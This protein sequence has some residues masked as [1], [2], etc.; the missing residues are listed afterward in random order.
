MLGA[1]DCINSLESSSSLSM[2]GGSYPGILSSPDCQRFSFQSFSSVVPKQNHGSPF[3]MTNRIV[4]PLCSTWSIS[5]S[6]RSPS[7]PSPYQ[8]TYGITPSLV[9]VVLL[10]LFLWVGKYSLWG[11]DPVSLQSCIPS[12]PNRSGEDWLRR[13]CCSFPDSVEMLMM[14][15][16][17]LSPSLTLLG[18]ADWYRTGLL[19]PG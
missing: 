13:C 1:L 11:L 15:L 10:V 8:A 17:P 5:Y 14:L 6:L 19:C 9:L 16:L 12:V 18:L 3:S 2:V 4:L 7:D